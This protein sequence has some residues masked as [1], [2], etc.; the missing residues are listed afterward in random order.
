MSLRCLQYDAFS[1]I[2]G[3]GAGRV[4][5]DRRVDIS[6]WMAGYRSITEHGF[7]ALAAL[8]NDKLAE[9]AFRKMDGNGGG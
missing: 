3:G 7:I 8:A 5:D 6:E 9:A 2:D 1:K 4:G